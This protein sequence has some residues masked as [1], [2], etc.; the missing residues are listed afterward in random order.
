M[1][2]KKS[3]TLNE[4]GL[5]LDGFTWEPSTPRTDES[6]T[7]DELKQWARLKRRVKFGPKLKRKALATYVA[8]SAREAGLLPNEI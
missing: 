3:P 5:P 8:D 1:A 7:L 4:Y 2:R 6:V